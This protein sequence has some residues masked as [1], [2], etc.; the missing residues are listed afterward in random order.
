MIRS[1]RI[2]VIAMGSSL[3]GCQDLSRAPETP[4]ESELHIRAT[5]GVATEM[6]QLRRTHGIRR[7]WYAHDSPERALLVVIVLGPSS[8]LGKPYIPGFEIKDYEISCLRHRVGSL[9]SGVYIQAI[10]S[11]DVQVVREWP[12]HLALYYRVDGQLYSATAHTVFRVFY[13][14]FYRGY[15]SMFEM[16]S[17]RIHPPEMALLRDRKLC[18]DQNLVAVWYDG[19]ERYY[20]CMVRD[21]DAEKKDDVRIPPP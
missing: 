11:R 18:E 4:L 5:R 14:P 10:V 13:S 15:P 7:V 3:L 9:H 12:R 21:S 17:R 6:S 8:I 19:R 1:S 2:L 20:F 16:G